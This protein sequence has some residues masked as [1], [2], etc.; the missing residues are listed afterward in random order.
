MVILVLALLTALIFGIGSR[1][2]AGSDISGPWS[3]RG[4]GKIADALRRRNRTVLGI[5]AAILIGLAFLEAI[6]PAFHLA[7]IDFQYAA[8]SYLRAGPAAVVSLGTGGGISW[9]IYFSLFV[10]VLAGTLAGVKSACAAYGVTR[11]ISLGQLI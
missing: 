2:K 10:A 6:I 4:P 5:V 3:R 8:G 11:G 1:V 9:G 7:M